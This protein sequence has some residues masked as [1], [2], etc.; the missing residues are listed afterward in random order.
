MALADPLRPDSK[1]I[2]EEIK[3][4]GIK[5]KILTGDNMEIAKEITKQ[6][7][8]GSKIIRMTDLD[9]LSESEQMEIIE[10][11]DGF[12]EIYPEDKYKIVKLL[13]SKGHIVGMTGDGVN[14][15]PALK[16]SEVGIAVSNSTDVAKT[17]ASIVLTQ[18]GL[19]LKLLMQ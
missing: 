9:G 4:F 3:K 1:S 15:S 13:Q 14:D 8:S 16:Q 19:K 6:V 12:A 18:P 2:V 10:D 7:S 11:C 17:S 5:V